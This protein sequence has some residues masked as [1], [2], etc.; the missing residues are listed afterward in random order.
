METLF[1]NGYT[2]VKDYAEKKG[3]TVQAVYMAIKQKRIDSK[4]IGSL[5]LVRE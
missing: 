5:V 2:T 3:V 1:K 4:K